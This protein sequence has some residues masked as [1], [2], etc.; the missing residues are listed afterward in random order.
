M[1][2]SFAHELGHNMGLD[3]DA[4]VSPE[5]S[6]AFALYAHG[7]V[8]IAGNFRTIMAY[9]NACP[10]CPRI[11]NFSSPLQT[12]GG[13]PTG[14]AANADAG[15]AAQRRAWWSRIF[16]AVPASPWIGS[17]N[18]SRKRRYR[19]SQVNARDRDRRG[20]RHYAFTL[21]GTPP[22]HLTVPPGTST[23]RWDDTPSSSGSD[24][25]QRAVNP[26]APLRGS[27]HTSGAYHRQPS[28]NVA[29]SPTTTTPAVSAATPRRRIGRQRDII[30]GYAPGARRRGVGEWSTSDGSAVSGDDFGRAR[31]RGTCR[32]VLTGP[33][34]CTS[35][36]RD[37]MLTNR[38]REPG[39]LH[40]HA[41][42]RERHG[43]E[44]G[45]QVTSIVTSR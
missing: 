3:H 39:D 22:T 26:I 1:N 37:P 10:S 6:G 36:D 7:Y 20:H 38:D 11:D 18:P 27:Q 25:R 24:H 2:Q 40:G 28:S 14:N 13:T 19:A 4:F 42:G 34:G 16:A 32:G 35:R 17:R 43:N 41:F 23:G 45:T 21:H 12:S 44:P 5:P 29:P 9:A 15:R 8:S 31:Q 33:P 30:H